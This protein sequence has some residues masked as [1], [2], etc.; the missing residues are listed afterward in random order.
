M[1]FLDRL[2]D[3]AVQE[4]A[5]LKRVPATLTL[6]L[7]V[8]LVG[9]WLVGSRLYSE[10]IEVLQLRLSAATEGRPLP[11]PRPVAWPSALLW[12]VAAVLAVTCAR[13]AMLSRNRKRE[14]KDLLRRVDALQ[15]SVRTATNERDSIAAQR[16][17]ATIALKDTKRDYAIAILRRYSNLR[18]D[19]NTAPRVTIRYGSY[20]CDHDI[21]V[22]IKALF[23]EH[24]RW[25]VTL[26]ASNIPALPRAGTFKV[27]FDTGM[28]VM[29][30]GD[31][32][33]AFADGDLLGVSVGVRQGFD[34]E[35]SHHLIVMVLPSTA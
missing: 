24:V 12:G 19:D 28:T 6:V 27:V 11:P 23:D 10:R 25:P 2:H 3:R 8:G 29:T 1:A 30:Y 14:I 7:I 21:A 17:S 32:V 15:E 34:R 22:R 35:D 13:L 31:L 9:G 16:D 20:G 18:F 26:D 33:H 4:V 5:E